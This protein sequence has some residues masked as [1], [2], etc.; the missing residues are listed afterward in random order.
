M[1]KLIIVSFCM[2]LM[3]GGCCAD[4]KNAINAYS[5]I[6]LEQTGAGQLLL[7]KCQD[8]DSSACKAV[9]NIFGSIDKSARVLQKASTATSNQ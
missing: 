9:D 4:L 8:G 5:V 3:L 7:K 6:V 2:A 1:K